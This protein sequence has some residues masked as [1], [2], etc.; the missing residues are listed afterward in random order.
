M[1]TSGVFESFACAA[2]GFGV[3]AV[4]LSDTVAGYVMRGLFAAFFSRFG[5]LTQAEVFEVA[6]WHLF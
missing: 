2:M 1:M 5:L 6:A 3:M 4:C